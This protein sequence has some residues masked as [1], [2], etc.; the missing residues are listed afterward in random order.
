[1]PTYNPL[2]GPNGKGHVSFDRTKFQ[3]LE[4]GPR[5]FNAHTNGGLTIL[6]LMRYTGTTAAYETPLVFLRN[7]AYHE[8]S[9]YQSWVNPIFAFELTQENCNIDVVGAVS[10]PANVII[11]TV[12]PAQ[13]DK[14]GKDDEI[15][16]SK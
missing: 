11:G 10:V 8:I 3:V 15:V 7:S 13:K 2:G 12:E 4:T 9:I 5:N 1:M 6:M 16:G 14:F